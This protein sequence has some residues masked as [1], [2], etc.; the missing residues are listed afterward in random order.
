MSEN[1]FVKITDLRKTYQ[2]GETEVHALAGINLNLTRGSF[3]VVMG[4]SGS[5]KSTLLYLLGGL[6]WP[7]SGAIEVDGEA[8]AGMD[9]ND[10]AVYRRTR[11][12]FIFQAFNLVGSMTALENAAPLAFCYYPSERQKRALEVL[13]QAW[14]TE[15]NINPSSWE[16]NNNACDTALITTQANLWMI[17]R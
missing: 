8:V 2:L 14:L 17:Y 9:E 13:E 1:G 5:G 11:I 15:C 4:P 3:N 12:G 7:T 6:D 10:P 16:G